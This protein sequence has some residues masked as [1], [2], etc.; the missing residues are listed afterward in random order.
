M[1]KFAFTLSFN[2]CKSVIAY[3]YVQTFFSVI[4]VLISQKKNYNYFK[5]MIGL[6]Y[7]GMIKHTNYKYIISN[8][9]FF[10]FLFFDEFEILLEF[11]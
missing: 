9:N 4:K 1:F 7:I 5:K 10:V 3:C 2:G 8:V 6:I 11:F